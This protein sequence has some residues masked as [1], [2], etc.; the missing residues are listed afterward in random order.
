MFCGSALQRMRVGDDR[1]A[2]NGSLR[3]INQQLNVTDDSAYHKPLD[4]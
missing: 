3:H 1:D 4:C 2:A